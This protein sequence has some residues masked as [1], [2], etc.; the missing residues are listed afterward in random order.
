MKRRNFFGSFV[1]LVSTWATG[2]EYVNLPVGDYLII[3]EKPWKRVGRI[4][5]K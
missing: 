1:A 5:F 3:Q 4:K 2:V